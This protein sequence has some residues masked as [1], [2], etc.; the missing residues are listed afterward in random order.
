M[1]SAKQ[2]L[3]EE[4]VPGALFIRTSFK[5]DRNEFLVRFS[6][7]TPDYLVAFETQ[8]DKVKHIEKALVLTDAQ[9]M[10][11]SNLYIRAGEVNNE[12]NFLS[13]YFDK[14][15]FDVKPLSKVKRDLTSS[16]IEGAVDKI[17][18]VIQFVNA[19]T[20]A[21][22][23]KG[24]A[25]DFVATLEADS[26]YLLA[27]NVLQNEV[28]NQVSGLY[29]ANKVEYDK[30]YDFIS[31]IANDGKVMYKGTPKAK[32]YTIVNIIERMRSGNSGGGDAN[33]SPA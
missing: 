31:A 15:G 20:A 17:G 3:R 22:V 19:N 6:E 2:F 8:I 1:S 32:E 16:N 4:Y 26:D 9:K 23:D 24:M 11:T 14:C 33:A 13:R 7:Y 25:A 21:L 18:G 28:K 12:F 10:A 27:Q 5:R 30:L 29:N